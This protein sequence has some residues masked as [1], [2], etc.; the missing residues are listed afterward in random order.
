MIG[1]LTLQ[2]GKAIDKLNDILGSKIAGELQAGKRDIE[3]EIPEVPVFTA[4]HAV[5]E[6]DTAHPK[7]LWGNFWFLYYQAW[8]W[9]FSKRWREDVTEAW[10]RRLR[11]EGK[12]EQLLGE[13]EQLI[14]SYNK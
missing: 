1:S 14:I 10:L 12:L 11:D 4:A 13:L 6:G 9:R 2:V 7:I 5:Y 8:L 3:L